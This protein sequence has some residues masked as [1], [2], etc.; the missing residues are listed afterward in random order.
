MSMAAGEV[1][2]SGD[3][4]GDFGMSGNRAYPEVVVATLSP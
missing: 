4:Y 2:I 3:K 1:L